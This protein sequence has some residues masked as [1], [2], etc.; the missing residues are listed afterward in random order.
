MVIKSRQIH[1]INAFERTM[2]VPF[3]KNGFPAR[4]GFVVS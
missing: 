3:G 1:R 2:T 4:A